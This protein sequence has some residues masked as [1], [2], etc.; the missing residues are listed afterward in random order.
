MYHSNV[1]SYLPMVTWCDQVSVRY[2]AFVVPTKAMR[3]TE[4]LLTFRLTV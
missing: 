3:T 1:V 4:F 2:V